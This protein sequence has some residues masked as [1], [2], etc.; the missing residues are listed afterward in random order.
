MRMKFGPFG[1]EGFDLNTKVTEKSSNVQD[2]FI[3]R[4]ILNER[5]KKINHTLPKSTMKSLNVM[6]VLI[7][8]VDSASSVKP[9][10]NL[11]FKKKCRLINKFFSFK[12]F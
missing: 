2:Q 1:L 7:Y 9:S 10:I 12:T 4:D 8:S 3:L 5:Q 11:A 6:K